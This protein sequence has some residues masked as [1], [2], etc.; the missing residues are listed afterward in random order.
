VNCDEAAGAVGIG[1]LAG[2][3][4]TAAVAVSSSLEAKLRK[5]GASSASADA[6]ERGR[7]HI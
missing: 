3:A 1:L 5:R 7:T 6:A 2:V 4:G